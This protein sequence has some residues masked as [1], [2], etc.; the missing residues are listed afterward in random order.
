M[1]KRVISLILIFALFL[2]FVVAGGVFAEKIDPEVY[3]ELKE[4]DKVPVIIEKEGNLIVANVSENELEKLE[5]NNKV[6]SVEYAYSFSAFLQDSSLLINATGAWGIFENNRNITGIDETICIIDT[7]I[8]FSHP[9]LR[10]KNKTCIIDC[11]NKACV[12]NCS[13]GDDNWHGT[14]VAGISAA[15]GSINGIANGAGLIGLKVL[16]SSGAA[17]PLSGAIDIANAIDWCV[18]NSARYNISVM[19]MSLGTTILFSDY[20]DSSFESTI[21]RAINNATVYNISVMSATGNSGGGVGRSTNSISAPACI[22]N[23]VAV[24]ATNKDDSISS[25]GH[26]SNITDLFAP[27]TSIN[28]T[29]TGGGYNI[30]SGTSMAAPHAAG[31]FA[32]IKQFY[33]L[34]GIKARPNEIL[35]LLQDNGK[36]ILSGEINLSRIDA[37]NAINYLRMP[38]IML[39]NPVNNSF[40]NKNVSFSCNQSSDIYQLANMTLS[41][42]NESGRVYNETRNALG[43][44]NFS[45]NFSREGEYRWNCLANNNKSFSAVSKNFTIVYDVSAPYFVSILPQNNS[46]R[47]SGRFNVSLNEK[48]YCNYSIDFGASN[49]TMNNYDNKNFWEINNSFT[50]GSYN[51]DYYCIDYAGNRNKTSL[52]FYVDFSRP[53][54]NL[55]W[56]DNEYSSNNGMIDF[57]YNVS[58]NLNMSSC[59]LVIDNS[60]VASDDSNFSNISYD[61]SSGEHYWQINCTDEAGNVGNSSLRHLIIT[62]AVSPSSESSG[63]GGGGGTIINKVQNV[64]NKSVESANVSASN[65]SNFT[66]EFNNDLIESSPDFGP[67]TINESN[68]INYG[69]RITG[70]AIEVIKEGNTYSY[71]SLVILAL[72]ILIVLFKRLRR[73]KKRSR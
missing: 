23:A 6:K 4:N 18:A 13:I 38:R 27:G 61:V 44:N 59:D 3:D 65:N 2:V 46:W 56:P 24:S 5:E 49:T 25:Y 11:Y 31:A 69:S 14:H 71:I 33:L 53:V 42:Y 1:K 15:S 32:L 28:S 63:G 17:S 29:Y 64:S 35:K 62:Q 58:D 43:L 66:E 37:Y 19:S 67:D 26:Y 72:I 47:N 51:V 9:A 12:E 55:S 16:D 48:G 70:R 40:V 39:I 41:I 73:K 20:C 10:N 52:K 68:G 7:G 54:I 22:A 8:D 34:A 21:T 60:V 30:L 50:E 57:R 45:Y 36:R